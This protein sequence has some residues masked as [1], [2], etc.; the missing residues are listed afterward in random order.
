[1]TWVT[2]EL[3]GEVH[4]HPFYENGHILGPWCWCKP[5]VEREDEWPMYTHRDELDRTVKSED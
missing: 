5:K 1:V 2:T 4:V 3:R